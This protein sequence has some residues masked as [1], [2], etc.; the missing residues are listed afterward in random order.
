MGRVEVI[1]CCLQRGRTFIDSRQV[2]D[3]ASRWQTSDR[4]GL[5]AK[6]GNIGDDKLTRLSAVLRRAKIQLESA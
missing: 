2:F 3:V 5:N 6:S 4:H 1:C